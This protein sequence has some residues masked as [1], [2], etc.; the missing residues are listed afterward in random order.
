MQ[1]STLRA[2]PDSD[3]NDFSSPLRPHPAVQGGPAPRPARLSTT[4]QL[5]TARNAI[6]RHQ[7]EQIKQKDK[8]AF[9]LPPFIYYKSASSS[10]HVTQDAGAMIPTA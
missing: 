2:A 3:Q 10:A 8:S 4:G 7:F 9:P 5:G 1:R 6:G